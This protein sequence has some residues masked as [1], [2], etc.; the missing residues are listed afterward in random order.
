MPIGDTGFGGGKVYDPGKLSGTK[1]FVK[2][3]AGETKFGYGGGG[4]GGGALLNA[5]QEDEAALETGFCLDTWD[6]VLWQI[7]AGEI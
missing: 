5:V 3:G 1:G 7:L 6:P 4:G 2:A